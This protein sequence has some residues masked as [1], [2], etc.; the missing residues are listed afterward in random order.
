MATPIAA[1]WL[2]EHLA[3]AVPMRMVELDRQHRQSG[4]P[5]ATIA[6]QSVTRYARAMGITTKRFVWPEGT[7]TADDRPTGHRVVARADTIA[8]LVATMGDSLFGGSR[9]GSAAVVAAA[10]VSGLAVGALTLPEG[11]TFRGQHWCRGRCSTCTERIAVEV[12]DCYE[13]REFVALGDGEKQ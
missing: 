13:V 7:P 6:E 4:I 10:L 8:A 3:F 2:D 11:I 5:V 9:T 12:E 1:E